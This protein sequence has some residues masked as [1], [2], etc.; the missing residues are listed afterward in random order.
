M[1]STGSNAVQV[2]SFNQTVV[3]DAIRRAGEIARVEISQITGLVPQTVTNI[4]RRLINEGLVVE[5]GKT[6]AGP[7]KPRTL[8]RLNPLGKVAIGVHLDPAVTSVALLDLTGQVLRHHRFTT[9]SAT[10]PQHVI[11][12]IA[13][14]VADIITATS[15][16][17]ER[18]LGVG[19]AAPGPVDLRAGIVDCPP[20]LPHWHRVPLRDE[21]ARVTNLPVILEKDVIAAAVADTWHASPRRKGTTV[22]VYVGTG[23]GVGTSYQREV[24]RGSSGNS[25]DVGHIVVDDAADAAQCSC[26]RRG[27]VTV[28]A[29]PTALVNRARAA[30]IHLPEETTAAALTA[31]FAR[32]AEG[33]ER[34]AALIS[35]AV[36]G[37][38]RM[39]LVVTDLYDA[40]R[41]V[42]GGAFWSRYRDAFNRIA[43]D[44][45]LSAPI[46]HPI[47][48]I[49]VTESTL[50]DE[51]GAIGA[52]TLLLDR[53]L[54]PHTDTLTFATPPS[55]SS[56][57][58]SGSR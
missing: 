7:G 26:G 45:L 6:T 28:T 42:F 19:I 44:T 56:E 48:S 46:A 11:A 31:L 35:T 29:S 38:A 50:G 54:T 23:I 5:A 24:I 57:A 33:D 36:T 21:L 58:A 27:C 10:D 47:H 8:I 14:A 40:D 55:V 34:A 51:L 43:R 41:L 9:P 13:A 39:A 53:Y 22:V 37:L 49:E 12:V 52:A 25:G 32:E 4:T 30:G 20:H 17:R 15:T 2:G 18:I 16:D 1:V 3:L